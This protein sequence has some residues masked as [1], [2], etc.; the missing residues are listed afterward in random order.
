MSPPEFIRRPAKT[1]DGATAPA[2]PHAA[3]GDAMAEATAALAKTAATVGVDP[4]GAFSRCGLDKPP[5]FPL[6]DAMVKIAG[7][8]STNDSSARQR[9]GRTPTSLAASMDRL[10][11]EFK[12]LCDEI[13]AAAAGGKPVAA[14]RRKQEKLRARSWALA[15]R[16]ESERLALAERSVGGALR[17]GH[18][19]KAVADDF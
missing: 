6:N 14:L 19:P 10:W 4:T 2:S 13:D 3:A 7:A 5:G 15:D 16:G 1:A 18:Q 17:W 9:R 12:I 11:K 8:K